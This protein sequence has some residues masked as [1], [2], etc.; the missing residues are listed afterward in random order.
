MA[1]EGAEQSS[2]Q[3][4]ARS[5]HVGTCAR[6]V[7]SLK[8]MLSSFNRFVTCGSWHPYWQCLRVRFK[9]DGKSLCRCSED[10][11]MELRSAEAVSC[12]E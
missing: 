6:S 5:R 10:E 7:T 11:T 12:G 1:T 4:S 3:C 8:G 2:V 9:G